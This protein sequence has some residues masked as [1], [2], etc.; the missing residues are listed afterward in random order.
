MSLRKTD[1][2]PFYNKC[3][4]MLLLLQMSLCDA[5]L[6]TTELNNALKSMKNISL[7]VEFYVHFCKFLEKPIFNLFKECLRK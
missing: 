5:E 6:T 1:A 2:K 4:T 3:E 7:L